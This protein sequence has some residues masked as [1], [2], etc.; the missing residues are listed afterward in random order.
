MAALAATA[1]FAQTAVQITGFFDA[2][3]QAKTHTDS[4]KSWTGITNNGRDTSRFDFQ[5]VE[6]LG[7]GLKASF[8]AELD[9]NPTV[10]QT[11]N[12]ANTN[13][14]S[15][16]TGTPFTGQQFIAIEG[17]FGK[18]MLGQPSSAVMTVFN[19][20]AQPFGTALGS[21]YNGNFGRFGTSANAGVSGYVGGATT[22]RIVRHQK[23]AML[24]TPTANGFTGYIEYSFLNDKATGAQT[25]TSTVSASTP[26]AGNDNGYQAFTLGY[27]NGPLNAAVFTS[28]TKSGANAA[29]GAYVTQ[30]T[31]AANGLGTNNSV[32]VSGGTANY[33][34][35]QTT[36]YWGISKTTSGNGTTEDSK[37]SNY[38]IKYNLSGTVDLMGNLLYRTSNLSAQATQPKGTVLGLGADYK[39]SKNTIAYYRYE[40]LSGLN[41]AATTAA[42]VNNTGLVS[43]RWNDTQ[44]VNMVGLRM[45]F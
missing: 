40:R 41:T 22:A 37:S 18:L 34:L 26:L 30:G 25:A 11:Q 9:L 10:S 28:Q 38:A 29:A 13:D 14:G 27:A 19:A 43:A 23:T 1:S 44:L 12:Q 15:V 32:T 33:N 7:A 36:V 2:G 16:F 31:Y 5:G 42:D 3:Y 6:D 24:Q 39:L 35:G 45:G 17:G 4:A 21:G 20:N 8:W